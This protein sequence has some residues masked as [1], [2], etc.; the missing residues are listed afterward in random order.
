M[1]AGLTIRVRRE[2]GY[3][4]ATVAGEIDIASVAR[5]RDRLTALADSG[6]PVIAD[7]DQV[8]FIDASGLGALVGASRHAAAHG[9]RLHVVCGRGPARQLFRLTGLDRHIPLTHTLAEAI[10][11]LEGTRH[12]PA[13]RPQHDPRGESPR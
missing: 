11:A 13:G 6:R 2:P 1:N 5:L 9:A 10:Q 7:L 8:S 12:A 4:V 3:A